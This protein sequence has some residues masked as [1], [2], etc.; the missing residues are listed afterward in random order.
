MRKNG[1]RTKSFHTPSEPPCE[2]HFF[3]LPQCSLLFYSAIGLAGEVRTSWKSS[4]L[5]NK[6]IQRKRN[7]DK[8][9]ETHLTRLSRRPIY[10]VCISLPCH[11]RIL[12]EASFLGYKCS[13]LRWR[14][15]NKLDSIPYLQCYSRHW[16]FDTF[17]L[18][19]FWQ[20][21]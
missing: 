13:F 18:Y 4:A 9:I 6:T 3:L 20:L 15:D 14:P 11:E 17:F 16:C 8:L 2:A 1:K 7:E 21:W 5:K 10:A 19:L 12:H